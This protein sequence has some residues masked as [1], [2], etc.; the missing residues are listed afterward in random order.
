MSSNEE[1]KIVECVEGYGK[2]N[3]FV[4]GAAKSYTSSFHELLNEH[5]QIQMS[6][7]KEPHF[8]CPTPNR[9]AL[10]ET[11]YFELFPHHFNI[12]YQI[13]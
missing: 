5:P 8:F 1:R 6:T 11:Q 4:I 2:P 13:W 7:L 3:L 12:K 10:S 9:E